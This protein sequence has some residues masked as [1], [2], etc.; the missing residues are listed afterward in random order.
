MPTFSYREKNVTIS[1]R[2]G[3]RCRAYHASS[4]GEGKGSPHNCAPARFLFFGFSIPWRVPFHMKKAFL[5]GPIRS[6]GASVGVAL[7]AKPY[8][9]GRTWC[10]TLRKAL[11]LLSEAPRLSAGPS[12]RRPGRGASPSVKPYFFVRRHHAYRPVRASGDS[13]VVPHPPQTLVPPSGGT[14]SSGPNGLSS[15]STWCLTPCKPLS[16]RPEAPRPPIRRECDEHI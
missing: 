15:G 3:A 8:S 7:L 16:L 4:M 11:F 14:T 2:C 9:S 1:V 6:G 12:L 13:D 10:L 5:S